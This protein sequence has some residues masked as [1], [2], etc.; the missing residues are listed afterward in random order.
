MP[1]SNRRP[2]RL[3]EPSAKQKAA[4][5]SSISRTTKPA[6]SN[7]GGRRSVGVARHNLT[8]AERRRRRK[9]K[10]AQAASTQDH[11][12]DDED[13]DD[14]AEMDLA[15]PS[16]APAGASRAN[17]FPVLTKEDGPEMDGEATCQGPCG[18]K[19][20]R[21]G[22]DA[23]GV[24]GKYGKVGQNPRYFS[25]ASLDHGGKGF[26]KSCEFWVASGM[27]GPCP[28]AGHLTKAQMDAWV[29]AL[30]RGLWSVPEEDLGVA[31]DMAYLSDPE[32]GYYS[33]D[34]DN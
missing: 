4:G 26:C 6:K 20:R 23:H 17:A 22:R 3:T 32:N 24:D 16:P 9:E 8:G 21:G 25:K 29:D 14:D 28:N 11:D 30:K 18:L 2:R 5:V 7:K 10:E 15:L 19:Y 27:N 13:E 34:D 1:K 12:N 33:N 31:S